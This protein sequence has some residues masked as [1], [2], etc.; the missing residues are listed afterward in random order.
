MD[1]I[2]YILGLIFI[3][4]FWYLSVVYIYPFLERKGVLSIKKREVKLLLLTALLVL[5]A[6]FYIY[7]KTNGTFVVRL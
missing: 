2:I 5:I 1:N 3:V 6:L 4:I 7:I